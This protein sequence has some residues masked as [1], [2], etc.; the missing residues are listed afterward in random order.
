MLFKIN[1]FYFWLYWVFIVA[2]GLSLVAESRGYSLVVVC[3]RLIEVA[4]LVAEHRVWAH[5]L[6]QLQH[7][8]S[9]AVVHGP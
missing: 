7:M 3:G 2:S 1:Y 8:G 4:S 6:Q 9:V 5:G